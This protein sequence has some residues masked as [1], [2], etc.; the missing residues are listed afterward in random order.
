MISDENKK[1]SMLPSTI[2]FFF[3]LYIQNSEYMLCSHRFKNKQCTSKIL[4]PNGPPFFH[5][6]PSHHIGHI[7]FSVA[8][9]FIDKYISKYK[10]M[11]LFLAFF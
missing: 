9:E 3:F 7:V 4:P 8:L 11:F 6:P 10:Y 1:H 5:L 2:A